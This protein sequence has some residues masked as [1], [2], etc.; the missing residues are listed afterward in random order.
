MPPEP[1]FTP[2]NRLEELLVRSE[3]EPTVM[4]DV[5]DELFKTKLWLVIT[6]AT[7]LEY[8]TEQVELYGAARDVSISFPVDADNNLLAFTSEE[9][10]QQDLDARPDDLT[11]DLKRGLLSTEAKELVSKIGDPTWQPKIKGLLLNPYLPFCI[12]LP[13]ESLLY[14]ERIHAMGGSLRDLRQE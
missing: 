14:A 12:V 3:A 8:L 7:K 5:Y 9:R 4:N 11:P 13:T 2:R 6:T 10:A 1:S